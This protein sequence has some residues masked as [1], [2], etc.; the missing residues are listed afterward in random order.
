MK[1][2]LIMLIRLYK[3][4]I[5]PFFPNTCRFHPTCSV[6]ASEAIQKYG[7]LKGGILAIKRIVKCHPFHKGGFDPVP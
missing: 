2:V 3:I 5:S 1:Y 4:T 7:A 6:Y